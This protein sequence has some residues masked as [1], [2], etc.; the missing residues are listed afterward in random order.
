MSE[1]KEAVERKI[2][3]GMMRGAEAGMIGEKTKNGDLNEGVRKGDDNKMDLPAP[4]SFAFDATDDEERAEEEK[5][6]FHQLQEVDLTAD[7]EFEDASEEFNKKILVGGD[8]SDLIGEA[9]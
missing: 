5:S 7:E 1:E 3:E 6:P 9:K 8:T 2:M 4:E